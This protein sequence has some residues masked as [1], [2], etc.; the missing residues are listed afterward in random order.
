[1]KALAPLELLQSLQFV[2]LTPGEVLLV[3]VKLAL[4]IG[5][6][7]ASPMLLYQTLMFVLPGLAD[8]E[9]KPV[10]LTV[11]FGSVLFA[12]GLWFS[13]QLVVPSALG[14][15]L[16]YG[17][18]VA[19]SQISIASYVDFCTMLMAVTGIL[20]ELPLV[21]MLLAS[22]NLVTSTQLLQQWRVALV[23]ILVAAA[24]LT[25]SQ[26]PVTMGI[27]AAAMTGL[28]FASLLP[29]KLMGK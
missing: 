4:V 10:L 25:P 23:A 11:I 17:Q 13:S 7:L 6:I 8:T 5:V 15:L 3:S 1:M 20:F 22:L 27:V 19:V 18:S 24:V 21:L 16:A 12:C 26:D 28:Y 14:F 2:Q 9:R 29:I